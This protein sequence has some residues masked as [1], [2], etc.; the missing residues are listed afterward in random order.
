MLG[1]SCLGF[2]F[3]LVMAKILST[4]DLLNMH[5][6]TTR[7]YNLGKFSEQYQLLKVAIDNLEKYISYQKT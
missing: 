5:E 3:N 4:E 1:I 2:I 7:K 6:S